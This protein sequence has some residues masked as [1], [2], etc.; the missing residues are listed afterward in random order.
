MRIL[1]VFHI[2]LL[3]SA[4]PDTFIQTKSSRINSKSQNVEYEVKNILNQQEIQDQ[5]HYL[6]K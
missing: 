4:D 5:F 2:F 6:I 1:S 3:K